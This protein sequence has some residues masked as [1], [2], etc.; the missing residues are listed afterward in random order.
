MR[1]NGG[2]RESRLRIQADT[3]LLVEGRDEVNLFEEMLEQR[4]DAEMKIQVI[5]AGG[6]NKFPR[7]LSAIRIAAQARP[8]LRSIGVVRDADDDADSAF[9]SVCD[10]LHNDGYPPPVA[11]GEFSDAIPSM[12]VFVVPD[13]S[14]TG[15][16][17]TLCRRSVD[18]TD[19][20]GC[21]DEYIA[22]LER[23]DAMQSRNTDKS[24]AH[25]YLAAMRDPLARVGEGARIGVWDLESPA[26]AALSGFLRDLASQGA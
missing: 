6:V 24:F 15:A 20:A 9:R 2:T 1:P 5:D 16:L 8:T 21:V 13:G 3:L 23:H 19:A 18:G 26:F 17:E 22:C 12:G 7:S 4:L 14:S 11:H 10:H 25:A